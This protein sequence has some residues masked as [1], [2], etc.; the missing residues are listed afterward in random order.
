MQS[1]VLKW[2]KFRLTLDVFMQI[3]PTLFTN[4]KMNLECWQHK[5]RKITTIIGWISL[6]MQIVWI[7]AIKFDWRLDFYFRCSSMCLLC[8][9]LWMLDLIG[10]YVF[11]LQNHRRKNKSCLHCEC[12]VQISSD[13][14][15][16][17][18]GVLLAKTISMSNLPLSKL[19]FIFDAFSSHNLLDCL[20]NWT[21]LNNSNF[22]VMCTRI[23]LI[24]SVRLLCCSFLQLKIDRKQG[25]MFSLLE[26]KICS[27]SQ[28]PM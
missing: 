8:K 20:S 4:R 10:D 27:C 5:N 17:L 13:W 2:I 9:C 25:F 12:R 19:E 22:I 18:I 1:I 24:G 23:R 15:I 26:A 21:T 7:I 16:E 6:V 28:S 3:K 11:H 14:R